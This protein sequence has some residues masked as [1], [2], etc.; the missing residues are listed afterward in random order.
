MS[1]YDPQQFTE[2]GGFLD[3]VDAVVESAIFENYDY[4]G[5]IDKPVVACH[6]TLNDGNTKHEQYWS[7][8]NTDIWGIVD[9]GNQ[10][11][12]IRNEPLR[13]S[14]N[15]AELVASLVTAGFDFNKLD[16]QGIKSLIGLNCTWGQKVQESRGGISSKRVGKDGKE[17]DRT[18]LIV[19]KIL[20]QSTGASAAAPSAAGKPSTGAPPS[21]DTVDAAIATIIGTLAAMN[22]PIPKAQFISKAM[23]QRTLPD[24]NRA[25]VV[26][27]LSPTSELWNRTDAGFKLDGANVILV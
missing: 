10:I 5:K 19:T 3:G 22:A 18:V 14:S 1:M 26:K 4:N 15:M 9:H 13:K 2:G 23:G 24:Q 12:N 21:S 25:E 8:G 20:G 11:E 16:T 7:V 6:L 17:Y 27:L